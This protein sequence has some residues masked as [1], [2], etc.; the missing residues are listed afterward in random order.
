[1]GRSSVSED[2]KWQVIGM[3]KTGSSYRTIASKLHVSKT[4][5]ENTVRRFN[6]AGTVIDAPRS[7][8][9]RK[10]T[11]RQDRKLL[12][13]SKKD[14]NASAPD[15][16]SSMK[17]DDDRYNSLAKNKP[18]NKAELKF[19]LAQ[20]WRSIKKE[21]CLTLIDSMPKRIKECYKAN[22]GPI[23]Y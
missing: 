12:V 11:P 10:T 3:Y 6:L 4:C 23:D 21:D 17:Q 13:M 15:L 1:M 22:G 9:P 20:I 7:G 18:K 14:R 2:I 8:R 19:M 16:L 5:V